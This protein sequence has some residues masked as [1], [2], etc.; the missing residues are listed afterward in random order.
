MKLPQQVTLPEPQA[1]PVSGGKPRPSLIVAPGFTFLARSRRLLSVR[2]DCNSGGLMKAA[3]FSQSKSSLTMVPEG[4]RE[5]GSWALL[6][7]MVA[8]SHHL[9]TS[10]LGRLADV[11]SMQSLSFLA[12]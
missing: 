2:A 9:P 1:T 7:I 8:R 11:L 3:R 4:P 5:A 10:S 12:P 6:L